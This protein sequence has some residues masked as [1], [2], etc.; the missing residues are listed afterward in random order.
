M[1]DTPLI[2]GPD[3]RDGPIGNGPYA[4][5]LGFANAADMEAFCMASDGE[6]WL[7]LIRAAV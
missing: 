7:R 4:L 5:A 2:L 1:G 3:D 6:P